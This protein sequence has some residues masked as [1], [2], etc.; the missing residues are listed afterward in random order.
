MIITITDIR[1]AGYCVAGVRQWS[2]T[3]GINFADLIKNGIP[4]DELLA[5]GDEHAQRVI[6]SK[7]ERERG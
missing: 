6:D 3:H 1:K 4:A 7:L 5:K 2:A